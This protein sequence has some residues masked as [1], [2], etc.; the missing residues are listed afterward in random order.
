[1]EFITDII[2]GVNV[3]LIFGSVFLALEIIRSLGIKESYV[4]AQGWKYIFPAVIV[5]AVIT[6]YNFFLDY[7]SYSSPRLVREALY[8]LF[9]IFLFYGLLV[10]FI[11]IKKA[12]AGRP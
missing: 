5:I 10:Q 7:S 8:L 2:T 9:N 12:I 1:M 4:L 11:A 6:V 3:V